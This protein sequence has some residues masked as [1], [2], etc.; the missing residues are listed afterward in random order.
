MEIKN[1][2]DLP[3][4]GGIVKTRK[5]KSFSI[6]LVFKDSEIAQDF[7]QDIQEFINENEDRFQYL[8]EIINLK[9]I[10]VS[11]VFHNVLI[12]YTFDSVESTKE[13]EQGFSTVIN[14]DCSNLLTAMFLNNYTVRSHKPSTKIILNLPI[15]SVSIF[16]QNELIESVGLKNNSVIITRELGLHNGKEVFIDIDD[17]SPAFINIRLTKYGNLTTVLRSWLIIESVKK[18]ALIYSSWALTPEHFV[19]FTKDG[20][21]CT[22][23]DKI[24]NIGLA[25]IK[26][27]NTIVE[28]IPDGE[29]YRI[30]SEKLKDTIIPKEILL[31]N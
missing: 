31:F 30:V 12:N 23:N 18:E 21:S 10:F 17:F 15:D 5:A 7:A 29:D 25:I 14:E 19:S 6:K 13:F 28:V 16:S 4:I 20:I 1:L 3:E 24:I 27:D 8:R 2:F 22:M 9:E 26:E 11:D